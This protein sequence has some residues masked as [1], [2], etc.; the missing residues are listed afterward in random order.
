MLK[1]LLIFI[2]EGFCEENELSREAGVGLEELKSELDELC[3]KGYL[4][5]IENSAK[6]MCAAGE[7]MRDDAGVGRKFAL[8]EKGKGFISKRL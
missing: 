6:G 1:K 8:T 2:D 3:R 7:N 5:V 4:K